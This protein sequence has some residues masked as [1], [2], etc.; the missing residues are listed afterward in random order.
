MQGLGLPTYPFAAP[1]PN[2]LAGAAVAPLLSVAC[3]CADTRVRPYIACPAATHAKCPGAQGCCVRREQV[4]AFMFGSVPLKTYLPDGDIDMAVFQSHG[5]SVRDSWTT[6][7]G[8]VLEAEARSQSTRFRVK[9]V[10]VI[11]AEVRHAA[12]PAARAR[13]RRSVQVACGWL[14]YAWPRW[15][16]EHWLS[17]GKGSSLLSESYGE[18]P[19]RLPGGTAYQH[20]ML[21]YGPARALIA[22]AC[23][24]TGP[25]WPEACD[26]C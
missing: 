7:L 24:Q 19:E 11:H 13:A 18:Q 4:Q 23:C 6:K 1:L 15:L 8:A 20:C 12:G 2:G 3:I 14:G 26:L 22:D 10:Q 5:P 17:A 16:V 21:G 25:A 9:D